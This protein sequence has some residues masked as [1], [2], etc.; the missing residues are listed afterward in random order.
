M[1]APWSRIKT[2]NPFW[3]DL[4]TPYSSQRENLLLWI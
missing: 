4:C 3:A 2:Q 1:T